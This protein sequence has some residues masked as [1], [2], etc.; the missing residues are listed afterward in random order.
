MLSLPKPSLP[1]PPLCRFNLIGVL[2][3]SLG[4]D[5]LAAFNSSYK[6]IYIVHQFGISLGIATGI[7][8]GIHLGAGDVALAKRSR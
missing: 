1:L 5:Q 8:V 4:D 6:V 3:A 2:A 7:R